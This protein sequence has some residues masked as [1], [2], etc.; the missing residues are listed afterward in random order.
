[1]SSITLSIII[2]NWNTKELLKKCVQSIMQHTRDLTYEIIV[3]DNHSDDGSIPFLNDIFLSFTLIQNEK[4]LGFSRAHNQGIKIAKGKYILLL[5]SDTYIADNAFY[6]MMHFMK[7]DNNIGICGPK[8]LNPDFSPQTTRVDQYSPMDAFLK[9]LGIYNY[10]KES[11][12][13][14]YDTIQEV[15][16]IGG[17]CMLFRRSVFNTVGLLDESYFLYNEENDIC[18][19]ARRAG[20]KI[21]FYPISIVF[22]IGGSSTSQREIA[23]TVVVACYKSNVYFYKKY[24]STKAYFILLLTYKITFF[25]SVMKFFILYLLDWSSRREVIKQKMLL[26]WDLLMM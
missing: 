9:I 14:D 12:R 5:N 13:M 24:F 4:N 11:E 16:V 26:K 10:R 23:D 19:R 2:V 22:H 17:C 3:V 6:S 7:G 15:E 8:V 1:M 25:L 20:W 21:V 18:L